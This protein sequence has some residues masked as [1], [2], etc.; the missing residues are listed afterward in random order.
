MFPAISAKRKRS[1][2]FLA[3]PGLKLVMG[4]IT[5]PHKVTIYKWSGRLCQNE[6][7]T[8]AVEHINCHNSTLIDG[9]TPRLMG[10]M[11]DLSSFLKAEPLVILLL[12]KRLK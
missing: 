8:E 5:G 10:I 12:T 4:I 11:H 9:R 2:V 3:K 1:L 6:E 7:A